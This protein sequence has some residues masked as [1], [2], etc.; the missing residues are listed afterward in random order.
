[1]VMKPAATS[2]ARVKKGYVEV[3]GEGVIW[4]CSTN[5]NK[6]WDDCDTDDES[7]YRASFFCIARIHDLSLS[8]IL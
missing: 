1:M 7:R 5:K 4:A 6:C 3:I 8:N 2:L